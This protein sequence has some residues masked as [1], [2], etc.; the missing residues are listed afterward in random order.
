MLDLASALAGHAVVYLHG[1]TPWS[2]ATARYLPSLR[3]CW[4]EDWMACHPLSSAVNTR[5]AAANTVASFSMELPVFGE[6]VQ[7]M[8]A[9]I[10]KHTMGSRTVSIK[11][12]YLSDFSINHTIGIMM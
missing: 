3:W 7:P 5:P 12:G 1:D 10:H 11:P 6:I 2:V 9:H 8:V 4:Y